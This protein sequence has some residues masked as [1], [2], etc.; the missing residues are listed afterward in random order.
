MQGEAQGLLAWAL[1]K[2]LFSTRMIIIQVSVR[3]Y[4]LEVI[5]TVEVFSCPYRYGIT[6]IH[7]EEG[8]REKQVP[9]R[10][11]EEELCPGLLIISRMHPFIHLNR[12]Y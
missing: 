7:M 9:G 11:S 1:V 10:A 12:H 4:C 6:Q 8:K 3:Y 2:A 5:L